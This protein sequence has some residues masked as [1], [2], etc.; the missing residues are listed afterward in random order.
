MKLPSYCY[1]FTLFCFLIIILFNLKGWGQQSYGLGF[2]SHDVVADQRTS[3]D[4]FPGQGFSP[5]QNFRL[6]FE[7]SFLP[8]KVDYFGYIFRIIENGSRNIDLIYNKRDMVTDAPDT[9][10]DHFKLVIDDRFTKIGFDILQK[11]LLSQW[12][13]I[14]LEFDIDHDQLLLYVNERKYVEPYA[15]LSKNGIYKLCFGINNYPN[16]KT[17]DAPPFKLRN[18]KIDVGNQPRF[19]WPLNEAQ[20]SVARDILSNQQS[21]VNHPLWVRSLHHNWAQIKTVKA[22]GMASMAFNPLT[23]EVYVIGSDS[24]WSISAKNGKHTAAAYSNGKFNLKPSN[25]SLFNIYD[26][27]LY[28]YYIDHKNATVA[29]YNFNA[30]TW[31]RDEPYFP[32]IDYWHSNNFFCAA[33]TSLYVVAGYG[34]LTYKNNVQRYHIPTG[35][36]TEI[37]T[38]GDSFCP[39]YLAACGTTD[40]GRY[41]Y[42]LGGYGSLSGQQMLNPKNIYDLIKYDV[43]NRTFKKIYSLKTP[44]EDFA[45]ANSMIIDEKAQTFTALSFSNH[46][47][48]AYLQLMI[49][50]LNHP[51]YHTIGSKIPFN[52]F[53]TH[54]FA[55]LYYS[56]LTQQFIAVTLCRSADNVSTVSVF[57]LSSPPDAQPLAV[58]LPTNQSGIKY[59]I[60]VLSLILVAVT[61]FVYYKRRKSVLQPNASITTGSVNSEGHLSPTKQQQEI[62]ATVNTAATRQ[63]TILLFGD[64]KLYTL[65]GDD[66]TGQ[67]T[68]LIK[69]LFLAILIYSLRSG[70]GISPEKLI[71]LLWFDKSETSAKNNRSANLSKLRSLLNQMEYVHLSKETGNWKIEIDFSEVYVDYHNYLQ[72]MV[73]HKRIDEEKVAALIEITQRGDFLPS[74]DYPWLDQIKSDLSN[75]VI[76]ILLQYASQISQEHDPEMLIKLAN[77]IFNFDPVNEEAMTMKCKA[78]SFLGKHSLA[79]STF[80]AFNKEYLALYGEEFKKDFHLLLRQ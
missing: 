59:Y 3:L 39:R 52:F 28:N 10:H 65:K 48:N 80:Q 18:I 72:L 35:K 38:R 61:G 6:S 53:D 5:A 24:L 34:Q 26:H 46:K 11:Q 67:F 58:A 2:Y 1:K 54:A 76:D 23:A 64:L 44:D 16:F 13:K 66:I 75:E 33:D 56:N 30:H 60:T 51:S 42:F 69:E 71:E 79:K 31:S 25:E 47:Y 17:N 45:L 22:Q 15:R 73:S 4:L 37:T 70:R 29:T 74:T 9:D 12:N 40:S 7:V 19:Y 8:D 43:K 78:L 57:T 41:A 36:W 63:R 32:I 55:N 77:C 14:I 49:G 21:T 50:S 20:G 27:K 62:T 68:S